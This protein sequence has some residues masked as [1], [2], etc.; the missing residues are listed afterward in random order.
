MRELEIVVEC[1]GRPDFSG[2]NAT[3]PTLNIL[4]EIW[5]D[6][7]VGVKEVLDLLQH[8]L[9]VALYRKV[10]VSITLFYQILCQVALGQ[11]CICAD[12]SPL[13][14]NHIEHFGGNL[15]LVGLFLLIAPFD[16]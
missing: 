10:V 4:C 5:W 12:G 9:L 11:Q 2:F 15:D 14:I 7:R 8:I 3:M 13:Y 1:S 16:R 6:R